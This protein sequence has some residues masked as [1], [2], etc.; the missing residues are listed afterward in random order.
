MTPRLPRQSNSVRSAL[1]SR[2]GDGGLAHAARGA[3]GEETVIVDDRGRFT[4]AE[5]V[6]SKLRYLL[7]SSPIGLS[8]FT[9]VSLAAH[10][11]R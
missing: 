10:R 4:P 2:R 9:M 1:S 3:C 8:H 6:E 11:P 7:R 5:A